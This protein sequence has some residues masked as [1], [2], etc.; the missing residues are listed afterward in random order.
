MRNGK[1]RI[2]RVQVLANGR[3]KFV[4]NKGSAAKAAPKKK[5]SKSS[6]KSNPDKKPGG[7][8]M[9]K[10]W[11]VG[12]IVGASAWPAANALALAFGNITWDVALGNI[13]AGYVGF[14]PIS[15]Q[16]NLNALLMNYGSI[17]AGTVASK[18]AGMFGVNRKLPFNI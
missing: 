14:D 11:Y 10:R 9:V 3:Y 5:K 2:Q 12:P 6:S 4:K 7:K 15:G 8:K 1:T 18:L 13:V 16:V 17:C